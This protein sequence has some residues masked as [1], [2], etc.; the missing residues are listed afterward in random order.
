MK[1]ILKSFIAALVAFSFFSCTKAD[2]E[3]YISTDIL[4]IDQLAAYEI[5]TVEVQIT[6]NVNWIMELPNWVMSSM[7][8][9]S[10]DA[11]I[12]LSFKD[13]MNE[14]ARTGTI[15]ISGGG[16]YDGNGVAHTITVSQNAYDVTEY[17]QYLETCEVLGGIPDEAEFAQ[18]IRAA[19]L[20]YPLRRW[21]DAA[22]GEILLMSDI[23]LTNTSVDWQ[24]ALNKTNVSN[25]A[26]GCTPNNNNKFTGK[27][28]GQ[29]HKITGFNPSVKLQNSDSFGLFNVAEG[30]SIRN[31]ILSGAMN[32]YATGQS[33]VGMLVGTAKNVTV[34]NVTVSGTIASTGI[35][36]TDERFCIGGVCGF[37][38]G[39]AASPTVFD[40]CTSEIAVQAVGGK[41]VKYG[42]TAA[43]YGG[44]VGFA[45]GPNAAGEFVK[46]CNCENNGDMTVT[47][48]RCSGIVATAYAGVTIQDCVNNGSQ[49]NAIANGRLGNIT[50][51]LAKNGKVTD[52]VNNGDLETTNEFY[53]GTIGGLVAL[54]QDSNA[55]ISGG[56]NYGALR[57]YDTAANYGMIVSYIDTFKKI[58][59]VKVGGELWINGEQVEMNETNY[60]DYF[61]KHSSD[62]NKSKVTG[63]TFVP[64]E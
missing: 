1:N 47:L 13:N 5:E 16:S 60:M 37:A 17:L 58:E 23:D 46:I 9:G 15:R 36:V 32:V 14:S 33:D 7:E 11:K 4:A 45:T 64:V 40:H 56:G 19:N 34:E 55:E 51:F 53:S 3:K 35:S 62:A 29:N 27:F 48:G 42:A 44:I 61:G 21:T 63:C 26:N 38:Y 41:N 8:C 2:E 6:S 18:F 28:N 39:T 49:A 54:I 12:T 25:T 43:M 30:A 20:G 57:T 52:C 10:G 59:D 31:L 24:F 50:C 22:T